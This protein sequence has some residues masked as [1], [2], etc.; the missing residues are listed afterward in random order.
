MIWSNLSDGEKL[1]FLIKLLKQVCNDV[2]QSHATAIANHSVWNARKGLSI[3]ECSAATGN[4][5]LIR[6]GI[7]LY[8]IVHRFKEYSVKPCITKLRQWD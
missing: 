5:N 8:E 2:I 4:N 6:R 7:F 1:T 3:I